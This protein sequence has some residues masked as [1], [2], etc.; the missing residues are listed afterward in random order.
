MMIIQGVSEENSTQ[1]F[2]IDQRKYLHL[3]LKKIELPKNEYS[4]D[5]KKIL[6]NEKVMIKNVR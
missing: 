3:K 6:G 2:Q 5:K 4:K 1:Y